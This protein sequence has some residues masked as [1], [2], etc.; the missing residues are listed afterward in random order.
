MI[1]YAEKKKNLASWVV[2][3]VSFRKEKEEKDEE[4]GTG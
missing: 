2:P 4:G 3:T 1:M